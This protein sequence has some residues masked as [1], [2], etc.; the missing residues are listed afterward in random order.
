M[1][2]VTP[3]AINATSVL[4]LDDLAAQHFLL[5]DRDLLLAQLARL[6]A[7]QQLPCPLAREDD[8]LEPI[9]LWCSFHM[10]LAD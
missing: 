9:F 4:E 6:G 2:P 8:E 1:P 3:S 5:R 7:L 10:S